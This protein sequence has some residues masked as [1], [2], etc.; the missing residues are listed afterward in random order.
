MDG[1][2][3]NAIGVVIVEGEHPG[4]TYYSAELKIDFAAANKAASAAGTIRVVGAFE[5]V[6]DGRT[7]DI[8]IGSI[9]LNEQVNV[10]GGVLAGKGGSRGSVALGQGH[11]SEP[12]LVPACH[13]AFDLGAAV[14]T[15]ALQVGQYH[16]TLAFFTMR[17]IKA[18]KHTADVSVSFVVVFLTSAAEAD[19]RRCFEKVLQLRNRAQL[20]LIHVDHHPWMINLLEFCRLL[21][22]LWAHSW[23][24]IHAPFRLIPRWTRL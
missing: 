21:E 1:E 2:D 6:H 24:E 16:P 19:L 10:T 11:F 20:Y 8:F 13:Q 9:H 7:T 17:V 12:V 22:P 5:E 23:V 3:L 14:A 15:G 4:S 18:L